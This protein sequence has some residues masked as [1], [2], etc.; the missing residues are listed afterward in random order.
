[1]QTV[2]FLALSALGHLCTLKG[3]PPSFNVRL[4]KVLSSAMTATNLPSAFIIATR[5]QFQARASSPSSKSRLTF[6]QTTDSGGQEPEVPDFDLEP[7]SNISDDYQS[8]KRGISSLETSDTDATG[9]ELFHMRLRSSTFQAKA[10]QLA[11]QCQDPPKQQFEAIS[12]NV[13][14][15][16]MD[17]INPP[18]SISVPNTYA[19]AMAPPQAEE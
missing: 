18:V 11:L 13:G 7:G 5:E 4:G 2:H 9:N 16:R 15:V 14:A 3:T 19:Q 6:Y 12:Q 10:R 8:I 1:M 17:K